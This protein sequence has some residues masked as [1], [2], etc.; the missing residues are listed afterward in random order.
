MFP[1]VSDEALDLLDRLIALNPMKR[2]S[3]EDALRHPFLS[4]LHDEE[5]EP[6]FEGSIDFGFETDPT[7]DMMKIKKLLL[8][9]I[10]LYNPKYYELANNI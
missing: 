1:G 4:S 9:E 8:N 2:I 3:I 5:D 6:T 10:G 7:L